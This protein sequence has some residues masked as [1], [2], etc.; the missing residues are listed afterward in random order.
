VLGLEQSYIGPVGNG[1]SCAGTGT[2]LY[3]DRDRVILGQGQSCPGTGTELYSPRTKTELSWTMN[4]V[5]LG[6]LDLNNVVL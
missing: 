6:R 4:R 1:Q 2:E 5:E 3:W